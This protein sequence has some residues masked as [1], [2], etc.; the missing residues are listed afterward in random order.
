MRSGNWQWILCLSSMRRQ[1]NVFLIEKEPVEWSTLTW[2]TV[3]ARWTDQIDWQYVAS[4]GEDNIADIGTKAHSK[5]VIRKHATTTG[6]NRDEMGRAEERWTRSW[7]WWDSMPWTQQ[8]C[9]YKLQLGEVAS[10]IPTIDFNVETFKYKNASLIGWDARHTGATN[11][12][13]ST[14]WCVSSSSRIVIVFMGELAQTRNSNVWWCLWLWL[15][16]HRKLKQLFFFYSG[17]G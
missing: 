5:D 3:V 2:Y 12:K 14:G 1:Q 10:T 13:E 6:Y 9:L 8:E 11:A 16:F 4:K 17:G 15:P 7:K